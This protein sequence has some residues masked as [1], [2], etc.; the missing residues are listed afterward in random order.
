[1]VYVMSFLTVS[2]NSTPLDADVYPLHGFQISDLIAEEAFIKVIAKYSNFEDVFFL[3]LAFKL[4][5]HTRIN[6]HAIKLVD[7][8]QPPYRPIF[9]LKLMELETLKA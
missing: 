9:N 2:L 7:G 8:Q 3:D 4:P 6:N 5:K 1:M